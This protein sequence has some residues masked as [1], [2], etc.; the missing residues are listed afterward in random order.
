M[1]ANCVLV[2]N[3][4]IKF[5]QNWTIAK[6][7]KLW[8]RKTAMCRLSRKW[9]GDDYYRPQFTIDNYEKINTNFLYTANSIKIG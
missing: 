6:H 4:C 1:I 8:E 7:K 5:E 3:I 9:G 2:R